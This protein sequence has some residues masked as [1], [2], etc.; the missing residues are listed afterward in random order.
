MLRH[1]PRLKLCASR[2]LQ[3]GFHVTSEHSSDTLTTFNTKVFLFFY[4][5]EEHELQDLS[6]LVLTGL[7]C[8]TTKYAFKCASSIYSCTRR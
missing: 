4:S 5:S 7:S 6:M 2:R 3:L 1:I 8:E